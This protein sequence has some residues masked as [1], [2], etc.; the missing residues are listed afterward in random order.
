MLIF[1]IKKYHSQSKNIIDI[2]YICTEIERLLNNFASNLHEVMQVKWGN[3]GQ[4]H[5][6][7]EGRHVRNTTPQNKI[8]N[9]L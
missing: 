2:T 8:D 7:K 6:G 1:K 5:K 4:Q 9:I 3:K